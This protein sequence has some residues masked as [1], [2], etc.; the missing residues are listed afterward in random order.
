MLSLLVR[1]KYVRLSFFIRLLINLSLT[2][3]V[4]LPAGANIV[5]T[6]DLAEIK[7]DFTKFYD[8]YYPKDVLVVVGIKNVMLKSL[9]FPAKHNISENDYPK[10]IAA[11]KK[12]NAIKQNGN[13]DQLLFMDY[14][15]EVTAPELLEFFKEL[16]SKEIKVVAISKGLTG[17]FNNVKNLEIWQADYLKK[18]NI[19]FSDSFPKNNYIIFNDLKPYFNTYPM[20]YNGILNSNNL[21]EYELVMSFII[22]TY[23]M[24]EPPKLLV[25]IHEDLNEL[26]SLEIVAKS[27]NRDILVIGYHYSSPDPVALQQVTTK[28]IIKF[29]NE[30]SDKVSK[31][32]RNNPILPNSESKKTMSPYDEK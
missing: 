9:V 15:N 22:Q 7:N 3:F 20:F 10:I 11:L 23:P 8:D 17:N 12:N 18:L 30:I 21:P 29:L 1:K 26:K 25:M 4:A 13:F 6:N 2:L 5:E 27:Y 24:Q 16:A 31:I 32:K 14:K 28:D 19:D